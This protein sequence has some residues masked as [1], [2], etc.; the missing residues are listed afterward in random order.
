MWP[1]NKSLQEV[2][3]SPLV[4][5]QE[6][7]LVKARSIGWK[8]QRQSATQPFIPCPSECLSQ[9]T[10]AS[11]QF[12]KVNI[13]GNWCIWCGLASKGVESG[14]SWHGRAETSNGS[15]SWVYQ[16]LGRH[17]RYFGW[18]SRMRWW[19]LQSCVYLSLPYILVVLIQRC[20]L[21]NGL[22]YHF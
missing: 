10:W 2:I 19:A 21:V 22:S 12:G 16:L 11:Q 13:A 8:E 3:N 4:I 6:I 15:G 1:L 5:N 18:L 9:V 7:M 20:V 14:R 17:Q